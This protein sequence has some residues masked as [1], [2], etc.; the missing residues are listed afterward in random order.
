M[1]LRTETNTVGAAAPGATPGWWHAPSERQAASLARAIGVEMTLRGW[2]PAFPLGFS[3]HGGIAVFVAEVPT[4]GFDHDY[5]AAYRRTDGGAAAFWSSKGRLTAE[6][7]RTLLAG[8][9]A[10]LKADLP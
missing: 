5:G 6:E 7:Q 3:R 4:A 2:E 1:N 8:L 9:E 10:G